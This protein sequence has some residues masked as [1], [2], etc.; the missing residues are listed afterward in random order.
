MPEDVRLAVNGNDVVLPVGK[1][2]RLIDLLRDR[3]GLMGTRFGCGEE[4]CGACMVLVDGEQVPSCTFAAAQA[5]HRQVITVEGLGTA[6]RPHAL[7][8]AFLE[9]QAGQCGYCLS[10]IMISAAALLQRNPSP[11]RQ[12]IIDALDQHLCRCGAHNRIIRAVERAA[13]IVAEAVE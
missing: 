7:Q 9:L 13:Q 5:A 8:Q 4:M 10:G 11:S 3:L 1:D 12:D 6:E 2:E